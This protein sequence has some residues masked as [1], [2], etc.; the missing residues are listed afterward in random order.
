MQRV[1]RMLAVVA[2]LTLVGTGTVLAQEEETPPPGSA[3]TV[4]PPSGDP[5]GVSYG[6]WGARWWQWL[7]GIPA[8]ENPIIIDAC[9]TGQGGEVFFIPHTLPGNAATTTCEVGADQWILASPGSTIW[10]ADPGQTDEDLPPLVEDVSAFSDLAVV[11]DGVEVADI[12]S[13]F[14]T[15]PIWDEEFVEDN[16][17][18][19]DPGTSARTIAGG[20]FVM[21]PPLEPGSH[22]IVVR[23]AVDEPEDEEGPITAELTAEITVPEAG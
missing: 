2:T 14:V 19:A 1:E 16:L 13:Y 20:W 21:I 4:V 23:D 15:T 9:G 5:L 10:S 22:T 7:L 11:I 8:A 17:F 18:G 6:E 3:A 12:E